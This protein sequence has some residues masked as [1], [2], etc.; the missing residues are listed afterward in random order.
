[1]C[2]AVEPRNEP[3]RCQELGG[4]QMAQRIHGGYPLSVASSATLAVGNDWFSVWKPLTESGYWVYV[5]RQVLWDIW[6]GE[7]VDEWHPALQKQE[8]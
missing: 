3:V 6:S 5:R 4:A 8:H 2:V 7:V 1:L